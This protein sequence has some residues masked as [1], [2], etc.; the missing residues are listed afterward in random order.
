MVRL[1]VDVAR[2][3]RRRAATADIT[4]AE[5]ARQLML[6]KE[7]KRELGLLEHV[8]WLHGRLLR[9][10][11]DLVNVFEDGNA[12]AALIDKALTALAQLQADWPE[13]DDGYDHTALHGIV[14][15]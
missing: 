5:A 7:V 4:I 13:E 9:R 12:D 2:A 3:L 8:A 14:H 11:E 1:P 15:P 10:R 6:R